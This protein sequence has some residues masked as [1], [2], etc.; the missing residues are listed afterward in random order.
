MLVKDAVKREIFFLE[1]WWLMGKLGGFGIV[2]HN[3][4]VEGGLF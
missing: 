3:L 1:F 2:A 4:W